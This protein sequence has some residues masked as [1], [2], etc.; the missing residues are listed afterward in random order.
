MKAGSLTSKLMLAAS[1]AF[2]AAAIA[3]IAGGTLAP[4]QS[5][6]LERFD[7]QIDLVMLSFDRDG[8]EVP[9]DNGESISDY[10]VERIEK[11]GPD[12]LEIVLACHGYQYD[13]LRA[14]D[15]YFDWMTQTLLLKDRF[16]KEYAHFSKRKVIVVGLHWPSASRSRLSYW[17]MRTR[18]RHVGETGGYTLLRKLQKAVPP[19]ADVVFELVGHSLGGVVVSSMLLGRADHPSEIEPVENL[20]IIEGAIPLWAY[21]S[22][23]PEPRRPYINMEHDMGPGRYWPI[24]RDMKVKGPI[25]FIHSNRDNVLKRWYNLATDSRGELE[26]HRR[27]APPYGDGPNPRTSEFPTFGAVGYYGAQGPMPCRFNI[28]MLPLGEKYDFQRGC[29]Y[30]IDATQYVRNHMDVVKP[31]LAQV[32]IQAELAK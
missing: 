4:P 12:G 17:Y 1:L 15:E 13:F 7:P 8:Y 23:I 20:I 14:V 28:E 6:F 18:A 26:K 11:E 25:I 2:W 29:V 30:N 3:C 22:R 21:C 9:N 5:L 32:I 31:E 10:L 19:G 24:I 16:N 27:P